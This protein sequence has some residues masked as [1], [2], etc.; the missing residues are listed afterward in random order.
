M[1]IKYW[2]QKQLAE[3]L[4]LTP[5]EISCDADFE[6]FNLDSLSLI[7][8]SFQLE[9]L[10]KEEISPTIFVEYNSINK[11]SEWFNSQK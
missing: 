1:E 8:L 4:G 6:T 11:L 7:S 9:K 5:Q 2:L 10:L 3:E